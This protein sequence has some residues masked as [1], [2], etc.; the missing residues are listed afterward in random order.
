MQ[1]TPALFN[2]SEDLDCLVGA[3]RAERTLF[4]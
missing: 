1:V 3:I 4:V 2:T